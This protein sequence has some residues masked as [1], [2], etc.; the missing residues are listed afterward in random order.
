M[1]PQHIDSTCLDT[2]LGLVPVRKENLEGEKKS[3]PIYMDCMQATPLKFCRCH[4][5]DVTTTEQN[6]HHQYATRCETE[7]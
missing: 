2:L 1:L 4:R 6:D 3:L 5:G 7:I